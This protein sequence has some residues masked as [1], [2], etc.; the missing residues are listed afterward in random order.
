V[1]EISVDP[2]SVDL[3]EHFLADIPAQTENDVMSLARE[4]QQALEDWLASREW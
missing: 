3:A 2:A 1:N 4:I